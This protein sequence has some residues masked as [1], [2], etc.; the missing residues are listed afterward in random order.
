MDGTES[1]DTRAQSVVIPE[2]HK[3]KRR[4]FHVGHPG[5][6]RMKSMH[7]YM[8]WSEMD[9]EIENLLK[10]CREHAHDKK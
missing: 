8:Y 3:K 10:G 7:S 2:I 6:L 1:G 9:S 4:E 5:I